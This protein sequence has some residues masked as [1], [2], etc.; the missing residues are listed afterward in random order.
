MWQKASDTLKDHGFVVLAVALDTPEAARPWIEAAKPGYPALIDR[1]H[2]VAALYNMVNVPEAVWIDETG[3][4]VRPT[5]NAGSYDGFRSRDPVTG[6]MPPDVVET[7][8]RAKRVYM[9]AVADWAVNGAASRHVLDAATARAR[10]SGPSDDEALAHAHFRLAAW[11]LAKGDEASAAPHVAEARRLHPGSWTI[12]RQTYGRNEQG[13]ATGDE[14]RA[15]V[16]A[17]GE[18]RYYPKVDIEG[19]P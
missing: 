19:M 8:A 13:F 18:R 6:E 10:L 2:H 7:T 14:F 1:E 15:R 17:L 3:R 12:F 9:E 16:A 5:E 4:I 11:F